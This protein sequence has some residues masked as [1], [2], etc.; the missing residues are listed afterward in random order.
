MQNAEFPSGILASSSEAQQHG[1][2]IAM[3]RRL[4]RVCAWCKRMALDGFQWS[5]DRSASRSAAPVT[6]GICPSCAARFE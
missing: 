5:D 6:H 3:R 4:R 1:T 2:D